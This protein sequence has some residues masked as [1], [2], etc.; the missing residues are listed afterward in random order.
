MLVSIN[1]T[2]LLPSQLAH[3]WL[4]VMSN[5]TIASCQKSQTEIAFSWKE[6]SD[7]KDNHMF[8][9]NTPSAFLDMI[10]EMT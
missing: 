7:D 4:R 9:E 8:T 5:R 1:I 2:F 3:D 10:L 6:D